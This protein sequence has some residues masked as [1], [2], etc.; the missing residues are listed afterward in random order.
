MAEVSS[1]NLNLLKK[2]KDSGTTEKFIA[3]YGTIQDDQETI[4]YFFKH[5][6]E[7]FTVH[8]GTC[9]RLREGILKNHTLLKLASRIGELET[10]ELSFNNMTLC[11]RKLLL[12]SG[13]K[14][15]VFEWDI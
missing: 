5:S 11:L 9:Q 15:T 3:H 10:M 6:D 1:K 13:Y 12:E 7:A 8:G 4:Y 2:F 14:V